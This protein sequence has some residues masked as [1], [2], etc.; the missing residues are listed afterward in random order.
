MPL[1]GGEQSEIG[2]EIARHLGNHAIPRR[3]GRVYP[4]GTGFVLGREADTLLSPDLAFVRAERLP[5]RAD[6]RGFLSVVP[7]LVV[8][9][10]ATADL[11]T[12]VAAEVAHYLDAGV[13]LVWTVMCAER[14]VSVHAAGRPPLVFCEGGALDGDGVLPGFRLPVADIFR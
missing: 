11:R 4:Y 2:A 12:E 10:V 7:D 1:A 5:V 3:F 9:V 13:R 14:S 6:R 8:I